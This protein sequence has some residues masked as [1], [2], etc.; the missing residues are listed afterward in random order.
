M[1]AFGNFGFVLQNLVRSA[2]DCNG[3]ESY[4][5]YWVLSVIDYHTATGDSIALASFTPDADAKLEH[6]YDIFDNYMTALLFFGRVKQQPFPSCRPAYRP[7]DPRA[8]PAPSPCLRHRWDDRV[9][10]GFMV[11]NASS[12]EAQF[13][14]RF[15]VL[16]AWSDWAATMS[17]AGNATAAEHYRGYVREK[18]AALRTLLGGDA[19]PSRLGTHAAAEALNAEGFATEAEVEAILAAQLDDAVH[20]CSLS[21]FNQYWILQAL[22][23][24]G[25]MDKAIASIHRCWGDEI[26]LGATSLWEA[27]HPDWLLAFPTGPPSLVPHAVPYG[28]NGQTSLC[29]P[30]AA[31]A[32]PWLSANVLGVRALRPGFA[33]V[34]ITPH[35]TPQMAASGGLRGSVPTPRGAVALEINVAAAAIA[36]RLPPGVDA[37]LRLSEP[38]LARMGL[39]GRLDSALVSVNGGAAHALTAAPGLRGPLFESEVRRAPAR[40]GRSAVASIDLLGGGDHR[41][42]LMSRARAPTAA[43]MAAAAP[44]FPPP[45]WP[46]RLVQVDTWTRGD[47]VG[48][49]GAD[50]Y[51]LASF[52]NSSSS[53]APDLARLPPYIA[54]FRSSVRG[55]YV[56]TCAASATGAWLDPDPNLDAR[57]LQ[58]PAGFGRA[59]G[60]WFSGCS[61]YVDISMDAAA[62]ASGLWYRLAVYVVDYDSGRPSHAGFPPRRQTLTLLNLLSLEAAAPTLYVDEFVGGTWFVFELNS[63]VRVRFSQLQGATA[64]ASAVTFDPVA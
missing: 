5:I 12:A 45:T 11:G 13:D 30:W 34:A 53:A 28:E 64:V 33:A 18:S 6:A 3:I 39:T 1:A 57:A 4:C 56:A 16:R 50:G 43:A 29:H 40:I 27:S 25:A 38:L 58:D 59:A 42:E 36:L 46:A 26:A 22:G 35:L 48:R 23:N 55:A 63:S 21:N 15:L 32:A 44:A 54:S 7:P 2:D 10:G 51:V 49:F 24:S 20:V 52:S 31:G 61:D 47:W 41:V 62:E 37:Q 19:W 14:F 9:G 8:R 17:V 60:F